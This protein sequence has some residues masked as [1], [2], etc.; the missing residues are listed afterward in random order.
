[1]SLPS[2]LVLGANPAWQHVLFFDEFT[3]DRINRADESYTFPSGKGINFCR[4]ARIHGRAATSL[5]QFAGG[6]VGRLLAEG[7]DEDGFRHFEVETQESSRSCITCCCRQTGRT[8][9]LIE[10]SGAADAAGIDAMLRAIES[11]LPASA[12]AVICGT[13]PRGTS[14]RLYRESAARIARA[15]IPLLVDS[16]E[17]GDGILSAVPGAILKINRDELFLMTGERA[18][19][20]ALPQ[21]SERYH[22]RAAAITDG[23]AAAFLYEQGRLFR[24][25]I[26]ALAK[27][28]NP[29][30]SGD[31]TAAVF[32]GELLAGTPAA[33]AYA[34]ALGAAIANCLTP[35][36]GAFDPA[37]AAAFT[38]QIRR[39]RL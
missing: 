37:R 1:M 13:L 27:P 21:L 30:G 2:I 31:T 4:A 8:T 20:R 7:L 9:E 36:C 15:G 24:Y 26:P 38:A 29:I 17:S 33:E 18:V 6:K 16:F 28:V 39:H 14:E 19:E 10:P 12:M 34:V 22:L 11:E 23:P 25:E 32:A 5:Y 35:V 3:P